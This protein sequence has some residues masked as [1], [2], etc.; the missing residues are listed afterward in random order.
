MAARERPEGYG[1]V[2]PYLVVEGVEALLD[3]C[4]EAF[5]AREIVRTHRPDGSLGHAEMR[6]G[7]SMVM[8]GEAG[9][10]GPMPGMIFLYVPDVDAVYQRAVR[11]GAKGIYEP[12]VE[13]HGDLMGAVA[14]AFGNQ[15]W[16]AS[17]LEGAAAQDL[18]GRG[19]ALAALRREDEEAIRQVVHR[20]HEGQSSGNGELFASAFAEEHDYVALNGTLLAG[21]TR[22]EN[23]RVHQE[24][25]GGTRWRSV[26]ADA[27]EVDSRIEVIKIR[28]LAPESAVVHLRDQVR[29]RQDPDQ[30]R[31]SIMTAVMQKQDGGRW[32]IVAFHHGPVQ[33]RSGGH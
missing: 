22:Q 7:D 2:T 29:P 4:A 26:A 1:T 32:A 11:A 5:G 18:A 16:I 8:A 14:D 21:Q 3:F 23:A 31:E 30:V 6:I 27:G 33:G 24:L 19:K 28:F 17:E 12:V 20:M 13:T 9:Q 10:D 25:Y 15:W